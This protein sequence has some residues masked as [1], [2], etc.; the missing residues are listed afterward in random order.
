MGG[1]L[2]RVAR[3]ALIL[4]RRYFTSLVSTQR[5]IRLLMYH[6][7]AGS[8]KVSRILP[9]KN[10]GRALTLTKHRRPMARRPLSFLL[11]ALM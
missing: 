2:W 7:H 4:E 10:G 6:H 11:T 5:V 8:G 1:S 9:I 3:L